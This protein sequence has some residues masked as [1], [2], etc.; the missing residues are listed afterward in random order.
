MT[1]PTGEVVVCD[2]SP[3][4][5]LARV[6][7]LDLLR[8][9]FDTVIVP[10]AVWHEVTHRPQAPGAATVARATWLHV[11]APLTVPSMK[12]GFG[13]REAMA[14]ALE[15]SALLIVDD[16]MARAAALAMGIRITGT[17]G[18]LRRAKRLGLIADVRPVVEQMSE[19]GL[20]I[21]DSLV[22]SFLR[23]IGE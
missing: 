1:S 17:L 22:E 20:R 15:T 5:V 8:R 11:R 23:E 4:I 18:V 2:A 7:H 9:V 16:G 6:D 10:P 13:E 19:N 21:S 14:L 3:L 12:L